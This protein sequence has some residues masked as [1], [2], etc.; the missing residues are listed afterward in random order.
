MTPLSGV[1]GP[2]S[3]SGIFVQV[4]ID[5][6][7]LIFLCI[8][9]QVLLDFVYR[10]DT[11]QPASLQVLLFS[12]RN[13]SDLDFAG[14]KWQGTHASVRGHLGES[15]Q[16]RA[17]SPWATL[18]GHWTE[19]FARCKIGNRTREQRLVTTT[20]ARA[21]SRRRTSPVPPYTHPAL[22]PAI[23]FPS[24]LRIPHLFISELE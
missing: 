21:L 15:V 7:W 19:N 22:P 11:P 16:V 12:L 13:N 1:L 14:W 10:H 20:L 5:N 23:S 24:V 6:T 9:Q 8:R 4:S 2:W 18:V 17:S 3:F